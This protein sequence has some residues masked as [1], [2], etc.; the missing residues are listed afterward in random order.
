[1]ARRSHGRQRPSGSGNLLSVCQHAVRGIGPVERG[2][3]RLCGIRPEQEQHWTAYA[4]AMLAFNLLGF[5]LLYALLR[6]QSWL[7]L[8]PAGMAPVPPDLAFNTAVSFMTNTN[9]QAYGGESTLSYLSQMAGL[10]VQNFVSAATGIA[11]LVALIRGFARRSARTVGNFY[12]DMT[13][14]TLYVLLP[15]ASSR[16]WSWSARACRR[17]WTATSS[18]IR[19]RGAGR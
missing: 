3:Y 13:R 2:I 12:V 10:T 17:L 5:L 16:R 11:V 14:A 19:W 6:A 8:N 15:S 7:P 4:L 9:W 18:P 1:M